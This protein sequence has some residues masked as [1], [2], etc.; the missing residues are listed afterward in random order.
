MSERPYLE[1]PYQMRSGQ[2][3]LEALDKASKGIQAASTELSQL[4]Q[5]LHEAHRDEQGEIVMGLALRYKAALDEEKVAVYELAI[6]NEQRPPA[7]DI[8]EAK[9]SRAV[10]TKFPELWTEYHASIA[11]LN[12]LKDWVINQKAVISANQ[13]LS[14]AEAP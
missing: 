7:A 9:A 2:E 11:R 13:S 5:Q 3:V 8:R 1:R 10:R 12:A 6:D 14:K 4:S